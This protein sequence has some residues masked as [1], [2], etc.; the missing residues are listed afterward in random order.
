D[1]HVTGV[2]TCALPIYAAN[3]ARAPSILMAPMNGDTGSSCCDFCW[4]DSAMTCPHRDQCIEPVGRW[5]VRSRTR[6]E[7][8]PVR[9]GV[10]S[11][12]RTVR[13]STPQRPTRLVSARRCA[14][15]V[16]RMKRSAIRGRSE[17]KPPG[18][19]NVNR[20]P[21]EAKRNPGFPRAD[22]AALLI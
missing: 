14:P 18:H 15:F 20:S 11:L 8:V 6:C 17:P 7:Y 19:Q 22:C 10:S 4:I 9:S 21:D 12:K 13:E 3:K 1:F 5:G 2:Q 16:A